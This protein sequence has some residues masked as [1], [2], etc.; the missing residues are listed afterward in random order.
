MYHALYGAKIW[1]FSKYQAK[2][3]KKVVEF[4]IH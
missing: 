2:T 3:T 1:I 4:N